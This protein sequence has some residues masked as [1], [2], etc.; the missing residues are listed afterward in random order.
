MDAPTRKSKA[1]VSSSGNLLVEDNGGPNERCYERTL[2]K[3]ARKRKGEWMD[4]DGVVWCPRGN[5][6]GNPTW[7]FL[8]CVVKMVFGAVGYIAVIALRVLFFFLHIFFRILSF[9]A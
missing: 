1:W 7:K 6:A 8:L 2:R 4:E 9:L 5:L 3:R